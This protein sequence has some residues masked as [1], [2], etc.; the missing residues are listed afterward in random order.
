M[1]PIVIG[2]AVAV[3]AL[4]GYLG[5]RSYQKTGKVNLGQA[6]DEAT[7]VADQI[8][9]AV[10]DVADTVEETVDKFT[11][12]KLPTAKQLEKMTKAELAEFAQK[13][14]GIQ[15]KTSMKKADMI[16]DLRKQH[17]KL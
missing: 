2:V 1:D 17:R 3:V 13:D 6:V 10:E 15:L 9:D 14:H 16:A 11:K 7:D 8:S 12:T 4:A 5:Y